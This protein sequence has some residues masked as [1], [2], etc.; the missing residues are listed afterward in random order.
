M[1]E[2]TGDRVSLWLK[3]KKISLGSALYNLYASKGEKIDSPFPIGC[4][5]N[6]A[7]CGEA[8]LIAQVLSNFICTV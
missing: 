6:K 3:V 4:A 1:V 2:C 7:G 8:N 5:Y